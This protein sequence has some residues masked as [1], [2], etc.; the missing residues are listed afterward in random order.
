LPFN[1][2]Y[3]L[4]SRNGDWRL[5][6]D[7][8]STI[9]GDDGKPIR[10]IGACTDI[11]EKRRAETK[12]K[13][14]ARLFEMVSDAIIT[15]DLKLNIDGWNRS[16]ERIFGYTEEEALDR[17]I[18]ELLRTKFENESRDDLLRSIEV[19]G[20]WQGQV[21]QYTKAGKP[22]SIHATISN[23]YDENGRVIGRVGSHRNITKR[24][25]AEKALQ[26]EKRKAQE[27]LDVAGTIIVALDTDG[28]ITM[29]NRK[30]CD[31]LGWEYHE[32]IGRDWFGLCIPQDFREHVRDVFT[33]IIS[34]KLALMEDHENEVATR[35]GEFRL[36]MWHN[37]L[38][39]DDMGRIIG[40][41]S[42]GEDITERKRAEAK[43]HE[44]AFQLREAQRVS[45]L[46]SFLLD[47]KTGT[48]SSSD[49]LKR[50][51]GI[52][53]NYVA[54]V[55]GWLN[56]VHPEQREELADYLNEEVLSKGNSFDREYRIIR[57]TDQAVRWVH[58]K[59][60]LVFDRDR[61]PIQMVGTIQDITER[62]QAELVLRTSTVHLQN[63]LRVAKLGPWQY[64][65]LKDEFTFSDEFYAIFKTSAEANDGYTMSSEQYAKQFVYPE[66]MPL[67]G[68]E[69]QQVL[70]THD[71]DFTRQLEHRIIYADGT[72]GYIA[73]RFQVELNDEGRVTRTYGMNQDITERYLAEQK[74][75]EN[76]ARLR[77]LFEN[78]GEGIL[79]VD[80]EERIIM[81]NSAAHRIFG[82]E[83]G[84]IV[85]EDIRNYI[86]PEQ[87]QSVVEQTQRRLKGES[88]T[89]ELSI[90]RTDGER[91]HVIT[92]VSPWRNH[93]GTVVGSCGVLRDITAREH[94][95]A[96]TR[97]ARKMLQDVI[98]AIP[99][100]IFWKDCNSVY[101]GCNQTFAQAAGLKSTEDI[102]GKNDYDMPWTKKEANS[103]RECDAR[104]M[105]SNKPEEHVIETQHNAEGKDAWLDTSIIPLHDDEG[106][107]IGILGL[108]Q[109][110]TETVKS[111]AERRKLED[112]LRQSQ[113]LETIGT[114]AGGIAHDFNNIL[115]PILV[116]SQMILE[117]IEKDSQTYEDVEQINIAAKR[118]R[119]LVRHILTFSR[120]SEGERI[121]IDLTQIVKEVVK[122]LQSS[123]PSTILL[124]YNITPEC[125]RVVADPTQI[126]QV[127]M[128]LCTNAYQAI[129]ENEG[130]IAV[131]L[132]RL[133][134]NA[135]HIVNTP[136][137]KSGEYVVLSVEDTG[138]GIKP[139][140][141]EHIFDPF[142]TTKEVGKG[143]G[144]G[145]SVAH[146]IAKHHGGFILVDSEVGKG[147]KFSLYLPVAETASENKEQ[148][149]E[150]SEGG[151]ERVLLV[152]DDPEIANM[153]RRILE[154]FGYSV[155]V[156]TSSIE[157]IE[158]FKARPDDYDIILTDQIMP[159]MT[160]DQLIEK[161]HEVK[162]DLPAVLMTGFST[163]V[164]ENNYKTFGFDEFVM[165]PMVPN[166]LNSAIRLALAKRAVNEA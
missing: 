126:H 101:M 48:W 166:Q 154:R 34:G 80:L 58:G 26:Y 82:V 131:R 28:L 76:E 100:H 147:S 81:A 132:E 140:T 33:Q 99:A 148:C 11:T 143:T 25:E 65:V 36:V 159:Q 13:Q 43:L 54:D 24:V 5:W 35:N 138:S 29:I 70:E 67:V 118:A 106:R 162:P 104:V 97:A 22:L 83:D 115:V 42:S 127:L 133:C 27:Y 57:Q 39:R 73:V 163:K 63:A 50:I 113:K 107:V 19:K 23:L 7:E 158:A 18:H 152:D 155:T 128:N 75:R 60:E 153:A 92:T 156:R 137:Y 146:G 8:G 124:N 94:A 38:L 16:A 102:I 21:T 55:E 105:N 112:Q 160:G 46:G 14:Q 141:L 164:N 157:C 109:D 49:I 145:L 123:L 1:S 10:L 136:D 96:E 93:E 51:F 86:D 103:Y 32:L 120:Q 110:I 44:S 88:S 15:I 91:R 37:A 59:G 121:N 52:D 66:D 117:D 108:Y 68:Q 119:D 87:R 3:R 111:K 90:L 17:N 2:E 135:N 150:A 53:K 149:E 84:S 134:F 85:G 61:I 77:Q 6:K 161:I 31:I 125:G 30:G 89:Y 139:E 95:A 122:L 114:L 47:V 72:V 151:N 64:D 98:D 45:N 144:L 56:I 12:L 142:F 78:S 41:L 130:R 116:T 165:K 129:G 9:L 4:L 74:L 69:I 79:I 20:Y 40:T 71:P 62:K